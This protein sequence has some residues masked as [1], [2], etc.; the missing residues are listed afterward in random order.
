MTIEPVAEREI[1]AGEARA[2]ALKCA[3][4]VNVCMDA[5]EYDE[6]R[7]QLQLSRWFASLAIEMEGKTAA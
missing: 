5:G 7:R 3:R 4:R 1:T 2:E 6:A